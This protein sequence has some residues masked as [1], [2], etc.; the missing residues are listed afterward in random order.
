MINC[1]FSLFANPGLH[2]CTNWRPE[3]GDLY[4]KNMS[5]IKYDL[6]T[7]GYILIKLY[8]YETTNQIF[9]ISQIMEKTVEYQIGVHY[10]FIDFKSAYDSIYREYLFGAMMEF[11]IPPKLIRLVKTTMSNVQCSVRIQSHLL[12]PNIYHMWDEARRRR[13]CMPPL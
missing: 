11:G 3:D 2:F 4:G 10:L 7:I 9:T 1:S 12:E 13:T 5:P 8:S 6:N